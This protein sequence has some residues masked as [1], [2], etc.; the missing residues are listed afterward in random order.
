M[1]LLKK[2]GHHIKLNITLIDWCGVWVW[3]LVESMAT[4]LQCCVMRRR[5]RRWPVLPIN[6]RHVIMWRSGSESAQYVTWMNGDLGTLRSSLRI[7]ITNNHPLQQSCSTNC[8]SNQVSTIISSLHK[9][10][11]VGVKYST[12]L[13][14]V[15][16]SLCS[17]SEVIW[18]DGWSLLLLQLMN[19]LLY[20][21]YS[22]L[23]SSSSSSSD[24]KVKSNQQQHHE[25]VAIVRAQL[26]WP[27]F[28]LSNT[29]A[30]YIC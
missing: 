7:V 13:Q 12:F 27:P 9:S 24:L 16:S 11:K 21:D 26:V 22:Q 3:R 10:N 14:E 30:I 20:S 28:S 2:L 15:F 17:F 5:G 1:K 18:A 8:S 19:Y 23:S 29:I 6:C 4:D 25:A